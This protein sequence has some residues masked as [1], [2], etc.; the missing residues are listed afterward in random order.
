LAESGGEQLIQNRTGLP[1]ARYPAA[2]FVDKRVTR[3]GKHRADI[4]ARTSQRYRQLCE[5]QIVPHLGNHLVQKLKRLDIEG[6]HTALCSGGRVRTKGGIAARTIGHAHRVLHK[7]LEDAVKNEDVSRNVCA[8]HSAPKV[9]E[10]EMIIVQDV[11]A[12][13]AKLGADRLHVIARLALF[14]GMRRGEVLA[15]RWANV[16]LDGKVAKVSE[17]LEKTKE[18]GIRVKPPKSKAG[19]RDI[20]LPDAAV[21]ALRDYRKAVL[22]QRMQLGAGKLPDSALVL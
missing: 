19:R 20:T 9:E 1:V 17:A 13:L 22:E 10:G 6:W 18:H 7:A 16:D 8:A 21:E 3:R 11:P 2:A 12:L 4:S 14:T 5:N 15:L